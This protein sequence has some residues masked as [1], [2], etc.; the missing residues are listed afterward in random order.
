MRVIYTL[1]IT[2]EANID[3][4]DFDMSEGEVD[5]QAIIVHEEKEFEEDVVSF[6]MKIIEEGASIALNVEIPEG[7][8]KE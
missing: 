2:K 1:T 3:P 8:D 7:D 6:V 5:A 4:S